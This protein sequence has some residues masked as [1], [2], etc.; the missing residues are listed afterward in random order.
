MERFLYAIRHFFNYNL[1]NDGQL[2]YT[3]DFLREAVIAGIAVI[4]DYSYGDLQIFGE[5]SN[6]FV[7]KYCSIAL[8]CK[9]FLGHNH[10]VDWVTTYPFN[11]IS[12]W[13][14]VGLD[15]GAGELEGHPT[16]N[17]DVIINNDVWL[18]YNVT[19]L[20][21]VSIG[22][23]AV[24][25]ANS[26]V[27]KNVPPYAIVGGNPARL[28]RYRFEQDIIDRLL[29]IAWWNWPAEKVKSLIPLLMTNN[30]A[31]FFEACDSS[32]GQ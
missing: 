1:K 16:T 20:S 32:E 29:R 13:T 26:L 31:A 14:H 18:G 10:R 4:G 9:V 19:I 7:G 27:T 6:L 25:G 22:N 28:I 3:K 11:V 2:F 12:R 23:G 8:N 30:L 21:G 5:E 24:V 15:W 17:G